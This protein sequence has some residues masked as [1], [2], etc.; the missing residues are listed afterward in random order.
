MSQ[1]RKGPWSSSGTAIN[2]RHCYCTEEQP[3]VL[4]GGSIQV[5]TTGPRSVYWRAGVCK[6]VSSESGRYSPP[7]RDGV[8]SSES[9]C[10]EHDSC[11]V[12]TILTR[13]ESLSTILSAGSRQH[14]LKRVGP[15]R[16][17]ISSHRV[18]LERARD[19]GITIQ[20][21]KTTA[22]ITAV[23]APVTAVT[24]PNKADA[25]TAPN[26]ADAASG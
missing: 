17:P 21:T 13:A 4:T 26:T 24:A 7:A 2:A 18:C 19:P 11:R 14:D 23:T 3:H 9:T 10:A 22:P 1:P 6:P 20:I 5:E 12:S 16:T 8:A 25:V 15:S